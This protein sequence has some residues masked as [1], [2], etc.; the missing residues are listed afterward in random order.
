M[1]ILDKL[2]RAAASTFDSSQQDIDASLKR[3]REDVGAEDFPLGLRPDWNP[4]AADNTSSDALDDG[5]AQRNADAESLLSLTS[6]LVEREVTGRLPE[7]SLLATLVVA[8]ASPMPS[9]NPFIRVGLPAEKVRLISRDGKPLASFVVQL[10]VDSIE[11]AGS[12][13]EPR[14]PDA[15]AKPAFQAARNIRTVNPDLRYETVD[16]IPIRERQLISRVFA[17]LFKAEGEFQNLTLLSLIE[18]SR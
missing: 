10:S 4:S 18:S 12:A 1:G 3:F 15:N 11:Q 2:K 13:V 7:S 6:T 8:S 14:A 9:T 17:S 16:Y 5:H